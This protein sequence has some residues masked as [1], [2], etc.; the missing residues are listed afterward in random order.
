MDIYIGE[1]QETRCVSKDNE[2]SGTPN[3]R[4]ILAKIKNLLLVLCHN[5]LDLLKRD[6]FATGIGFRDQLFN[7]GPSLRVQL[8]PNR[9]GMVPKNETQIFTDLGKASVHVRSLTESARFVVAIL[10]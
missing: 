4:S 5:L 6:R 9:F 8:Q 7:A 2:D 1:Q 10:V 3:P